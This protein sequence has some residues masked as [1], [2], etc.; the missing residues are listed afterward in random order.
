[1]YLLNCATGGK[2]VSAGDIC[3]FCQDNFSD[4]LMI[5]SYQKKMNKK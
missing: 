2:E 1:M 3:I 4:C 5:Y